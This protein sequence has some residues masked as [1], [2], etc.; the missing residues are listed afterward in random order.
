M[1]PVR[2]VLLLAFFTLHYSAKFGNRF[3]VN[4]NCAATS[5]DTVAQNIS[6]LRIGKNFNSTRQKAT[7]DITDI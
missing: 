3:G 7:P 6:T 2:S 4:S 1:L 5:V